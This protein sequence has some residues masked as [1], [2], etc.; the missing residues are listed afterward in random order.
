M[1]VVADRAPDAPAPDPGA[2]PALLLNGG[3]IEA[4]DPIAGERR[5]A[6]PIEPLS[7]RPARS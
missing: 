1:V 2:G 7:D 5:N 3:Y 4:G 6:R